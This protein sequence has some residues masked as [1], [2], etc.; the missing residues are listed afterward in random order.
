MGV[1]TKR[2]GDQPIA[3]ALFFVPVAEFRLESAWRA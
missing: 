3:G 1:L 2:P